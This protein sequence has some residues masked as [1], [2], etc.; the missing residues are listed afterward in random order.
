MSPLGSCITTSPSLRLRW[1]KEFIGLQGTSVLS[2]TLLHI[3]RKGTQRHVFVWL[4]NARPLTHL[5]QGGRTISTLNT[6]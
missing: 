5:L 1:F 6:K 2:Q 4:G 3:A